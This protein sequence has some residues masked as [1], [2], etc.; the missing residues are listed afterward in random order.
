MPGA[1]DGLGLWSGLVLGSAEERRG[2]G[3]RRA[4]WGEAGATILSLA[5]LVH[6]GFQRQLLLLGC[7]RAVQCGGVARMILRGFRVSTSSTRSSEGKLCVQRRLGSLLLRVLASLS[8]SQS[9]PHRGFSRG[10]VR[11]DFGGTRLT[12]DFEMLL[13]VCL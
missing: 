13:R 5:Q 6:H 10:A 1:T 2:A 11:G 7:H 4:W 12:P 3:P 9:R 8:F